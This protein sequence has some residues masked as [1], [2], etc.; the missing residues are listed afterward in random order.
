LRRHCARSIGNERACPGR[1]QQERIG[2]AEQRRA[3]ADAECQQQHDDERP[4]SGV[5]ERT[6]GIQQVLRQ[7]GKPVR[8]RRPGRYGRGDRGLAQATHLPR[9]QVALVELLQRTAY[10]V[11]VR[12]AAAPQ[13]VVRVIEMLRELL[14]DFVLARGI[15]GERGEARFELRLP[16]HRRVRHDPPP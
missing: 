14:H 12:G 2:R 7:V 6:R 9:E 3:G 16:G 5:R 13:L 1:L 10:G 4:S 15:E 8:A 11:V